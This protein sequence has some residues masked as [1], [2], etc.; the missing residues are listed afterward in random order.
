MK[1]MYPLP[2]NDTLTVYVRRLLCVI[3]QGSVK[4]EYLENPL[5]QMNIMY[6]IRSNEKTFTCILF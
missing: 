2:Q 1:A 5:S 3:S 4:W 6:L